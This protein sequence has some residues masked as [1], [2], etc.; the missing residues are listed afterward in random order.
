MA[1]LN[2]EGLGYFKDKQDATIA[3]VEKTSKAT[4]DYTVG[5][6]LW[7]DGNLCETIT[8]IPAGTTFV[9]NTNYV[10]K[11]LA[12]SVSKFNALGLS[13]VDGEINIT[14]TEE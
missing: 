13:V 1:S 11:K 5:E 2:F 7:I 3:D 9:Q 14:Y 12:D 6:F 8:D 4:R 10:V